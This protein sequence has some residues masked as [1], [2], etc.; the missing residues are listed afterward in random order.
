MIARFAL[1]GTAPV[2]MPLPRADVAS[3]P[4]RRTAAQVACATALE[5]EE[6]ARRVA[7]AVDEAHGAVARNAEAEEAAWEARC[8]EAAASAELAWARDQRRAAELATL[9]EAQMDAAPWRAD[10]G[11]GTYEL[12]PLDAGG[13]ADTSTVDEV[14]APALAPVEAEN[15]ERRSRQQ[16]KAAKRIKAREAAKVAKAAAAAAAAP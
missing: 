13:I 8:V 12:R 16:R 9:L 4:W 7:W 15:A 6:A 3:R 1:P 5:A 11:T 14:P 10:D 2:P